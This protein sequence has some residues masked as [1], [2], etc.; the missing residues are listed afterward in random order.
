MKE[1]FI[2]DFIPGVRAHISI[3]NSSLTWVGSNLHFHN[4]FELIQITQS[5]DPSHDIAKKRSGSKPLR[6]NFVLLF[7][8]A[9]RFT[10]EIFCIAGIR[11]NHLHIRSH[12]VASAFYQA[13]AE[14][15]DSVCFCFRPASYTG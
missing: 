12:G 11:I 2:S 9:F 10:V 13:C 8:K 1:E 5:F 6:L 4:E 14:Y 7:C 15:T 3:G